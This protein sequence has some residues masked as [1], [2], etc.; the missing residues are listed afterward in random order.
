MLRKKNEQSDCHN[1]TLSEISPVLLKRIFT[2]T[3]I[4]S[5]TNDV[6]DVETFLDVGAVKV[7]LI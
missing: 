5:W 4:K 3:K 7:N 2:H 1:L 6:L